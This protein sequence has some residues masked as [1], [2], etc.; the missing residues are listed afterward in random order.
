[1]PGDSGPDCEGNEEYEYQIG[2]AYFKPVGEEQDFSIRLN[3]ELSKSDLIKYTYKPAIIP[4]KTYVALPSPNDPGQEKEILA[5]AKAVCVQKGLLAYGNYLSDN[6]SINCRIKILDMKPPV[7]DV[8]PKGTQL[9]VLEDY[10][11][12]ARTDPLSFNM[13]EEAQLLGKLIIGLMAFYSGDSTQADQVLTEV[14][15]SASQ[16]V[17]QEEL[18]HTAL[19]Y[20]LLEKLKKRDTQGARVVIEKMPAI[21]LETPEMQRNLACLATLERKPEEAKAHLTKL[22]SLLK[23]DLSKEMQTEVRALMV[24]NVYT[25]EELGGEVR[26]FLDSS[27]VDFLTKEKDNIIESNE[28]FAINEK[29]RLERLQKQTSEE[30]DPNQSVSEPDPSTPSNQDGEENKLEGPKDS[31]QD[32]K[33]QTEVQNSEVP[34]TT[35]PKEQPDKQPKVVSKPLTDFPDKPKM[36]LVKGGSF[37]MGS[38]DGRSNEKPL[39]EVK[40]SDFYLAQTEVT[41]K[42]YNL[43]CRAT[44]RSPKKGE[45]THPV[46]NVSWDDAVAYCKW[47][48][49]ETGHTYRLPTEAEWE[50]AARGGNAEKDKNYRYAGSNDLDAVAWY[51]DNSG[52]QTHPVGQKQP[53]GLGLYDMSGNVWEWCA[54][55]YASDY[56]ASSPSTNPQGPPG[57]SYRVYRGGSWYSFASYLRVAYR[58]RDYPGS[59]YVNI[60]FRPARTP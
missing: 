29:N 4:V 28:R 49:Q 14:A 44:E 5:Q 33:P 21:I 10:V 16:Q 3:Q 55:W 37:Q 58:D 36:I 45:E 38:E 2:L 41:V 43:F 39:H 42:Q 46:V 56:Y 26:P 11:F 8:V 13:Q 23:E 1:M 24:V 27:P 18:F 12:Y 30:K 57:G 22:V 20:L 48:S 59:Q 7:I 54:D 60:G 51:T 9:E 32:Q 6:K 47:L 17:D 50:F 19:E 25:V 40:V 34:T 35:T 31:F 52:S 53:N 15:E